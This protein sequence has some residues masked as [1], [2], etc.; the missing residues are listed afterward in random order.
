[1]DMRRSACVVPRENSIDLEN[2]GGVCES[3][4]PK[5]GIV[6]IRF[7]RRV[8]VVACDDTTVDSL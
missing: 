1:M 2:S 5:H 7:V 3:N 4:S 6:Y 8:A